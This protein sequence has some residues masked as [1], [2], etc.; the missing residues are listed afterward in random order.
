MKRILSLL[1][2]LLILPCAASA[3]QQEITLRISWW[4]GQTRHQA[5]HSAIDAYEQAHPG[6]SIECEYGQFAPYYQR[7]VTQLRS[8]SAPDIMAIDYKWSNQLMGLRDAFVN[9]DTLSDILPLTD[10]QRSFAG[11]YGGGDDFLIGVPMGINAHCFMY[12]EDF[13]EAFGLFPDG[14]TTWEALMEAGAR[15]NA[16]DSDR[17][18]LCLTSDAMTYLVRTLLKQRAG[19]CLL[20]DAGEPG[21]TQQELADVFALVRALYDTH[22]LPPFEQC[23]LYENLSAPS[24]PLWLGERVGIFPAWT[25]AYPTLN[26]LDPD[27]SIGFMRY[28]CPED[29]LD[30]GALVTPTLFFSISAASAHPRE[31]ADFLRYLLDVTSGGEA[32]SAFGAPLALMD[33]EG[34]LP[35]MLQKVTDII[36]ACMAA[37]GLPENGPSLSVEV[38]ALLKETLHRLGY[39]QDTPEEAAARFLSG[40]G[41]VR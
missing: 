6:V 27:F 34:G 24:N 26:A 31:A 32:Q 37:D 13:F 41:D 29:A 11:V 1:F 18:L 17:Y 20:T 14:L 36:H 16:Q 2:L 35:G 40:L 25:S 9:I 10:R 8:D 7:L 4:G 12:N 5:I 28:P 21:C 19:C 33:A 30:S 39:G 15:V 23:V 38:N 3:A 22:T